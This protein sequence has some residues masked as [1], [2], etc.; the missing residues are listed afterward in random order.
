MIRRNLWV[1]VLIW[2]LA[3][4]SPVQAAISEYALII[5][6]KSFNLDG[7]VSDKITIN[8]S[9]P[10]PI[11][12][13][14]EGDEAVILVTNKMKE[15]TS[16]HWHGFLLP[17][18]MD[19]VPGF[20]GF[21]GIK[22]G[23]TF[24]YRFKIRQHGTYWY[25]A[26]SR[27]QEQDGHYGAVIISPQLQDPVHADRDYVILLSDYTEEDS[28]RILSNLK[29]NAEH[30]QY[31]RPT[32]FDFF[33]NVRRNG[34]LRTWENM[35]MW[36]EMRMLPS[37]LSDVSGYTFL[38]NGRSPEE[39]WTG[40]FKVGD[41]VRLRFINASAMTFYD[42]RISGL[43][44]TVVAADGQNVEPLEIDEFRFGVAETYDVIVTP[45]EEKAYTIVAEPVDR[46]GFALATLAPR[47]GMKGERPVP[48]A[49]A[50][51]TM[52]DM[53]MHHDAH[54]DA[55]NEADTSQPNHDAG[56]MNHAAMDHSEPQT[57]TAD[58]DTG[59]PGSGWAETGAPAGTIALAYKNLRFLTE[60]RDIRPPARELHVVLGGNMKRYTW[61]MNG[62]KF[63]DAEPIHLHYGESIR[64]KLINETMMAHTMHLHGMFV[65]IENGQP[66]AKLPNKHTVII[67]PGDT[68]SMLLTADEPGEW[69]FHCHMIYHM[70][71]GMMTKVIVSKPDKSS[72]PPAAPSH[73][74][75]GHDMHRPDHVN[76]GHDMRSMD[77]MEAQTDHNG[78]GLPVSPAVPASGL[79]TGQ[80][81]TGMVQNHKVK[82]EHGAG[83]FHA[84]KLEVGGGS[85][86]GNGTV[87]WNFDGWI[88]TDEN[89]L[90][91][92][93]EGNRIN[94]K[95]EQAEFRGMYSRNISIFW[96]AQIGIRYDMEPTSLTYFLLGVEGLAPYFVEVEAHLFVSED[97]DVSARLHLENDLLVTQ[98]LILQ[99]YLEADLY[100]QDVAER[101]I[102]AGLSHAE[103]GL[104]IRYEYTRKF[105]P[106]ID[107]KYERKF[108]ETSAIA[109]SRG[110]SNE[111]FVGTVGLRLMF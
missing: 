89:K 90:W 39:N 75:A 11:L 38:V 79:Y 56:G 43:K 17:E 52:A 82:A 94:G 34:L 37:D 19:G 54:G 66:A 35:K 46:T 58:Y 47:K 88:G 102:G 53:G 61:T 105:A 51:L 74:D 9:I 91:M 107:V 86:D 5:E 68:Y 18:D 3:F 16:I 77:H 20:G 1:A 108:G 97:G 72:P 36:G 24:I 84:F 104:Q 55:M 98:R 96:D 33:A 76:M 48:R 4:V 7:K 29:M 2:V 14:T 95:T 10:G 109:K 30:Y 63:S 92:K 103:V 28:D 26:H 41:R 21:P 50:S 83:I 8:G 13:F 71:T 31:A 60:Q 101:D 78:H 67:A 25:H 106:Y 73:H 23:E 70:L 6:R 49:R 42:V 93:S 111:A 80:P 57:D 62:K 65:Q 27:G 64:L 40:L 15:D 81:E 85:S 22:L 59:V 32:V 44:M 69:A 45:R 100:A 87:D 12:R 99:P 110:E